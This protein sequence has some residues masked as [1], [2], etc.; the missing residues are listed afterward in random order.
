VNGSVLNSNQSKI[1]FS[2]HKPSGSAAVSF[3]DFYTELVNEYFDNS[4]FNATFAAYAL[5]PLRS[6]E[7]TRVKN[8]FWSHEHLQ[9]IRISKE[10]PVPLQYLT[11]STEKDPKMLSVFTNLIKRKVLLRER[12][13][14]L[15]DVVCTHLRNSVEFMTEQLRSDFNLLKL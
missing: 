6:G 9:C 1:V 14:F 8:V 13:P 4:Y 11:K 3:Y 12:S 7:D 2:K 10:V 15:Y 5:L